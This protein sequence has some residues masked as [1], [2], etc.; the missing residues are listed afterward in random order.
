MS[1]TRTPP[2]L[3]PQGYEKSSNHIDIAV[4]DTELMLWR[5]VFGKGKMADTIRLIAN[6]EA[7]RVAGVD[8]QVSVAE[9]PEAREAVLAEIDRH[10]KAMRALLT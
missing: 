1:K 2:P 6:R 3:Q 10:A 8:F 4:T 9:V 5:A 7:Y